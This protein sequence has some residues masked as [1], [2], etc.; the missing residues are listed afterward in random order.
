MKQHDKKYRERGL[1]EKQSGSGIWWIRYID[2][3]GRLRREKAGTW[4]TARDLYIKRK[5]QTLE[6]I[7]LPEKL[8]RAPV[9]FREIARDALE[10]SDHHKRSARN[11]HCRMGKLLSWFGDRSAD[12]VTPQM[13]ED[14]F[15][16][17][18]W[19]PATT[20]RYR[21]LLSLTYRLAVRAGKVR[22]N[23]ARMVRHRFEGNGRVRFLSPDE[24]KRLRSAILELFPEH[25]SEFELAL[26]TGLRQGE[27][28]RASWKDVNLD[29]RALTVPLD[30]AGRSSH[31][32]LN[33]SALHALVELNQWNASTELVC[34]GARSPRA[35]FERA[36]EKAR[37][38]DFRWHDIRH[39]FASR[40]VMSGADLRTVAE[41]LRD[42]TLAMVMRYAHLA[43]DY[44][45][46]AVERMGT[47]FAQE[48]TDTRTDTGAETG[49]SIVEVS[50][51]VH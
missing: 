49:S 29:R 33:A 22:E 11:D 19:S 40:L 13:I 48:R 12:S 4:A 23:P 14:Q 7:K 18:Q 17:Q 46:A 39:T 37:I 15:R 21:A 8:R 34:G 16:A 5:Q 43:P 6:G 27:Q 25:V 26:H 20:N 3:G 38:R 41:L 2:T 35:W 42:T 1:Y 32:P 24:E 47:A 51:S 31:V 45:L 28:Y 10:Y 50:P 9:S 36:L 30:K 44:R